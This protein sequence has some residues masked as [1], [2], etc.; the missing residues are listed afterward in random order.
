MS[1][2][3]N[4]TLVPFVLLFSR[5]TARASVEMSHASTMARGSLRL[6]A[7]AMQPL[8]VPRSI[9][10]KGSLPCSLATQSM[11]SAVSGRGMSTAGLTLNSIPQNGVRPSMYC[12]G[13]PCC[14]R[15][16]M[17]SSSRSCLGVSVTLLSFI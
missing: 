9:R 4:E 16:K 10:R 1:C 15:F 17:L 13:S 2:S 8:P 7:I 6:S 12:S 5:A 3:K 11:S 14:S